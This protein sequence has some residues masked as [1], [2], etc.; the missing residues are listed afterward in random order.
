MCIRDR[1]RPYPDRVQPQE[2]NLPPRSSPRP[3]IDGH[4][5]TKRPRRIPLPIHL[6]RSKPPSRGA[7]DRRPPNSRQPPSFLRT[8]SPVDRLRSA[9][10]RPF[11]SPLPYMGSTNSHPPVQIPPNPSRSSGTTK[12]N[13]WSVRAN[14]P[15]QCCLHWRPILG[16]AL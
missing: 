15:P 2:S 7:P 11:H 1:H 4:Q 12:V 3:Y 9:R 16:W 10:T 13:K 5:Y 14:F 8:P 6:R